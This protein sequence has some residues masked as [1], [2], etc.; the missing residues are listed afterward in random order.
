MYILSV[1]IYCV[2]Y[3]LVRYSWVEE[4][5][6]EQQIRTTGNPR[7]WRQKIGKKLTVL[8]LENVEYWQQLPVVG[9]Q[10]LPDVLARLD[11]KLEGLQGATHDRRVPRIQSG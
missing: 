9:H 4:L 8:A 10:G 5:R 6:Q 2:V 7:S 11:Q 3:V 1:R